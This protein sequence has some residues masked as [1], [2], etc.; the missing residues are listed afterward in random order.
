MKHE[1]CDDGPRALAEELATLATLD[2]LN[3]IQSVEF[4]FF[5]ESI[6]ISASARDLRSLVDPENR[7]LI[8]AKR[9]DLAEIIRS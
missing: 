6:E 8:G 1:L 9:Q 7:L 4:R 2:N 3:T 5:G